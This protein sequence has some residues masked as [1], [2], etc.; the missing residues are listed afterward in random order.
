MKASEATAPDIDVRI[1]AIAQETPEVKVFHLRHAQGLA[2]PAYQ[3]GAHVELR[4]GDGMLRQYSLCGDPDDAATYTIAVKLEPESRGGSRLMHER[5]RVGDVLRASGPR[6]NFALDPAA[7]HSLLL[8]AGIGVTP[9]LAMARQLLREHRPFELHYF[10]RSERDTAFIDLLRQPR[11]AGGTRLHT[12]LAP[13]AVPDALRGILDGPA[14]DTHVYACGP[15]AFLDA[16]QRAV[17]AV[18]RL[19]LHLEHFSAPAPAADLGATAGAGTGAFQVRLARSGGTYE[20]GEGQ[21]IVRALEI[22][23]IYIDTSC[24]EGVCGTCIQDVLEGV[25]EHRDCV[26]SEAEKQSCTKIVPCVSR[27]KSAVLVLDL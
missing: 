18:P 27:S 19:P 7:R 9:L 14:P 22:H 21:S 26:L 13:E 23:G 11:F 15:A 6:N 20:V 4:L 16:A 25:P 1:H 12:G 24:E 17:A 10:S 3:A 2:M 8:A 5:L